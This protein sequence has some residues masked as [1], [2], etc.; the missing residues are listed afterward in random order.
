MVAENIGDSS[1]EYS[2]LYL[3]RPLRENTDV[4]DGFNEDNIKY[5]TPDLVKTDGKEV[6]SIPLSYHRLGL[7]W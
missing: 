6:E 3:A 7:R 4:V 2:H 5:G 1:L